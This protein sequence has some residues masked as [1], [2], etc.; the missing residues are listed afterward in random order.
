MQTSRSNFLCSIRSN[1]H[2]GKKAIKLCRTTVKPI[3]PIYLHIY[4]ISITIPIP[5]TERISSKQ[6]VAYPPPPPPS[7]SSWSSLTKGR[8]QPPHQ[9]AGWLT[10]YLSQCFSPTAGRPPHSDTAH[11]PRLCACNH[12]HHHHHH[13][14]NHHCGLF[15]LELA[16]P[17]KTKRPIDNM[18]VVSS[19]LSSH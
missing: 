9:V 13:P 6:A 15:C 10:G 18:R 19:S 16:L 3:S 2:R 4:P 5:F 17:W 1:Q 12:H 7:S 8:K 14:N 11:R